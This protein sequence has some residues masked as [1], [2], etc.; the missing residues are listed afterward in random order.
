MIHFKQE[1]YAAY[2][3]TDEKSSK[4]FGYFTK[5]Q[6][7]LEL[8]KGK[9]WWGLNGL[10]EKQI[11]NIQIYESKE[12]YFEAM[13]INEKEAALAKLTEREKQLLGL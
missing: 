13:K 5:E 4:L 10:V 8:S 12:E 3:P 9:G 2:I 1:C 6:D 7:A 11:V